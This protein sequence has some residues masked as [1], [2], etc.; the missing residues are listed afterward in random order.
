M[1]DET[2]QLGYWN[3]RGIA[4]PI[5]MMLK[6][7]GVP[8]EETSYK[9]EDAGTTWY[10]RKGDRAALRDMNPLTTLPYLKHKGK[11]IAHPNAIFMYLANELSLGGDPSQQIELQELFCEV[12]EIFT[13]L[14]RIVY[15]PKEE[16]DEKAVFYFNSQL[17][18]PTSNLLNLEQWLTDR[19]TTYLLSDTTPCAADFLLWEALD[20]LD[21]LALFLS[22]RHET[23][24]SS[25]CSHVSVRDKTVFNK[26]FQKLRRLYFALKERKEMESYFDTKESN[27]PINLM[28]SCFY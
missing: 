20:Q 10:S 1:A 26:Q 7:G 19:Q 22:V 15:L 8:F 13:N 6:F 14:T 16:F 25:G 27:W 3:I 24:S 5:R 18:E 2:Y 11:V 17:V 9:W 12:M 4:A 23:S 28:W 21:R